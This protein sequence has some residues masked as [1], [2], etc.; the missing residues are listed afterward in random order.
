MNNKTTAM[1]CSLLLVFTVLAGCSGTTK[2]AA[3]GGA[4]GKPYEGTTLTVASYGGVFD[5][6]VKKYVIT[7]FEEETGAKVV[8]DPSYN[9][10]KLAADNKNPSVDLIVLDDARVI[11]GGEAGL[12]IKLDSSKIS[13]WSNVYPEMIDANQY[14]IAWCV[15][16]YGIAY[17]K[18]KIQTP[19]T[20]WNDLWN[21]EYKGKVAINDLASANGS[22]QAFVGIAKMN[23]GDEKNM[24]PAF[25]KYKELAPNL[26]T[27]AN[28]TPQMTDLL[29]REDIWIAPWWDGRAL[30]LASTKSNI[31]FVRPQEGA[32]ATIVETAIPVNAKNQELSYKFIN[33]LLEEDAQL[34]FA[35]DMFYGPTN[36][37][38][39]LPDDLAKQV[40]YGE[41][42]IKSLKN[43]DWKY[44]ATVRSEWINEWNQSI[45]PAM[46]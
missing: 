13:N 15:G 3:S 39:K 22:V 33:M 1:I 42:G 44:V 35:K 6:A 4:E 8:L 16:S 25:E 45:V 17:N 10:T 24:A 34:G 46:K 30:N 28:S 21:P 23:G 14:G 9:Y 32:Y 11:Q 12:L 27:I 37:N 31:G 26:L 40:V 38:V 18:D 29:T 19:P 2:N 5:E 7:K 43:V 36:K 41:E 20:S